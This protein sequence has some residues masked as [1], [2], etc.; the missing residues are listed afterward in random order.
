MAEIDRRERIYVNRSLNMAKIKAVGFDMDHTLAQ[1]NR[2]E[3]EAL[4]FQET[5][6]KF[7]EAGYPEELKTL[8]FKPDF[9]RRGLLIDREKGNV[10][11]VDEHKYVK[12]G[13]HGH[14]KLSKE[15]RYNIYNKASYKAES[16][17]SVDTFFALSET[18]L[19]IEIVDFARKN[20]GSI[21]KSFADVYKDLRLFIDLSHKDGSIKKKVLK[22]PEKYIQ[23]D[24]YL[25]A[26]LIKLLDDKKELFLLTNSW[27]DYTKEVMDFLLGDAND[28]FKSWKDYFSYSIVGSGKPGFFTGSQP[29]FEV[30]EEQNLMRAHT[31]PLK[32]QGVYHGGNA[33]LFQKLTNH[34]GDEILY[35]G[36]HIYG[37]IMQSKGTLN[38]RTMLIVEELID[39]IPKAEQ[40]QPILKKIYEKI[41][42][43]E[44]SELDQH[45]ITSRIR[46]N[47]RQIAK[48]IQNKEI[49]KAQHLEKQIEKLEFQSKEKAIELQLISKEIGDLIKQKESIFHP[50]W[51][52]LMK[53]GL[54]RSRFANQVSSYACIY[55]ASTTSLRSYS[56]KRFFMSYYD[57]LPHDL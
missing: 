21:T 34:S 23:K 16:F 26:T 37:D 51:G 36:D 45:R 53:V 18:Q 47:Q 41:D 13:Y 57:H 49:K 43:Q 4:A 38:W 50:L 10:L 19:F 39:E 22:D 44:A 7:I 9:L 28:D 29:F 54:E 46:S 14:V 20:P 1:Y 8:E 31:G 33:K 5:L 24:K 32:K 40:A 42:E 15:E 11:R 17:L 27:W 25:A 30:I 12:V 35:V 55:G 56:P 6:K 2:T 48:F 52:E 3:F